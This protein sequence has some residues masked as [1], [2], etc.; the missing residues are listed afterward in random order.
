MVFLLPYIFFSSQS[1]SQF[2]IRKDYNT[3]VNTMAID[4]NN[5]NSRYRSSTRRT[6]TGTVQR[7][8]KEDNGGGSG[9]SGG[10]GV[11]GDDAT[12]EPLPPPRRC[13]YHNDII[14]DLP[15]S[16]PPQRYTPP[17]ELTTPT[18]L[19][20]EVEESNN[21]DNN[22]NNNNTEEEEEEK[23]ETVYQNQDIFLRLDEDDDDEKED[24]EEEEE[25]VNEEMT[26][27]DDGGSYYPSSKSLSGDEIIRHHEDEYNDGEGGDDEEEGYSS[28]NSNKNNSGS[29]SSYNSNSNSN[30][31]TSYRKKGWIGIG[32]IISLTAAA[33]IGILFWKQTLVLP[34]QQQQQQRD[35]NG[36]TNNGGDD[37]YGDDDNN[38]DGSITT[39]TVL[40]PTPSPSQSFSP[41]ITFPYDSF[42]DYFNTLLEIVLLN[43]DSN[44]NNNI[45]PYVWTDP[46]TS[47][48]DAL[49]FVAYQDGAI[50]RSSS[51]SDDYYYGSKEMESKLLQRL[52]LLV[53]Y[54]ETG[55]EFYWIQDEMTTTTTDVNV[56]TDYYNYDNNNKQTDYS[57]TDTD[58]TEVELMDWIRPGIDECD[59]I[60]IACNEN[61]YIIS[62]LLKERNIVGNK[63]IPSETLIWLGPHLEILDLSMNNLR[64]SIPND[65]LFYN[66]NSNDDNENENENENENDGITAAVTVV[67]S[68]LPKLRILDLSKNELDGTIQEDIR[69]GLPSLQILKLSDNF[70]TG[71]LPLYVNTQVLEELYLDSNNFSGTLPFEQWLF[72]SMTLSST[73]TTPTTTTA[74][75]STSTIVEEEDDEDNANNEWLSSME[76]AM[77]IDKGE[78]SAEQNNQVKQVGSNDNIMRPTIGMY[79]NPNSNNNSNNNNSINNDRSSLKVIDFSNNVLTGTIPRTVAFNNNL[80][81][82][83]LQRNAE[84]TGTIPTEIAVL[85]SLIQL[86]LSDCDLD[87]RLPLDFLLVMPKLE[88]LIVA[89]NRLTGTIPGDIIFTNYRTINRDSSSNA[90]LYSPLHGFNIGDNRMTGTLP[91]TLGLLRNLSYL[92]LFGN[93]FTGEIPTNYLARGRNSSIDDD[94]NDSNNN[95]YD[96]IQRLWLHDNPNLFGSMPCPTITDDTDIALLGQQQQQQE[97]LSSSSLGDGNV[98]DY[99]AVNNSEEAPQ[100]QESSTIFLDYASD[101]SSNPNIICPCCNR[102]F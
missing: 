18:T 61:G 82:L 6:G 73:T 96:N 27:A 45:N 22:N 66:N 76:I 84:L 28:N 17:L 43:V 44:S 81:V 89:Y 24:E 11:V 51:N 19:S 30:S 56:N 92:Q 97:S 57:D 31:N 68:F 85:T 83:A 36:N 78:S 67:S 77:S 74:S 32:L 59:W 7:R 15:L 23:G 87:G 102:C 52:G 33:T 40:V 29:N 20:Q 25:S 79:S 95:D 1:K 48:F 16:P 3:V 60:G 63:F 64:G 91:T 13:Q 99:K 69:Y 90:I 39:T 71:P 47:Q 100:Q 21:T 38:G 4:D 46:T 55:G 34:S 65:F 50:R 53:L 35:N 93:E 49:R 12:D 37:Y 41:T 98:A 5:N 86:Q 101:C 62:L 54:Y 70:L 75:T 14:M 8:R 88:R 80:E 2:S 9:G 42:D 26:A 58:T 94:D 72:A 10:G